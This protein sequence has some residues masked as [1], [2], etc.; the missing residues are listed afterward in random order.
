[1]RTATKTHEPLGPYPLAF[2]LFTENPDASIA[3]VVPAA[4]WAWSHFFKVALIFDL[5]CAGF[6]TVCCRRICDDDT[7]NSW[8]GVSPTY[9]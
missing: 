7:L 6:G 8:Q 4:S 5:I 1:M 3:T 2:P 9:Y